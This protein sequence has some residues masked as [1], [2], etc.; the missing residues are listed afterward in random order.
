MI[1]V[2]V[3]GAT[4][5]VIATV[6][7]PNGFVLKAFADDQDA[8]TVDDVETSGFE[9]LYDGNIF[10]FDKTAPVKLAVS[11]IPGSDDDINLKILLQARKSLNW[12]N[13][14]DV[15]SMVISYPD[16]GRVVL[17]AGSILKGPLADTML[18]NG[19]KKGNTYGFVFGTFAGA[20]S[21]K[22]LAATVARIGATFL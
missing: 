13:L 12:L 21:V 17:S 14:P 5:T 11:V 10:T 18:T 16:G 2:S 9:P 19:R 22:E 15:T 7:F 4:I 1:D 20:Q 8:L 6:S 3:F